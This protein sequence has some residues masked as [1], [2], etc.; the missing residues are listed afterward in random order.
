MGG[1]KVQLLS[2][3][4]FLLGAQVI[5]GGVESPSWIVWLQL[6]LLPQQSVI[7]QV[8]VMSRSHPCPL[9][10]VF[11]TVIVGRVGQQASKASGVSKSHGVPQ[12]TRSEERRVGK[13]CR[14]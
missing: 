9:V 12:M 11:S 3:G 6:V 1:L 2:Q 14:A 8:R 4:T 13:E 10:T 5:F 7:I